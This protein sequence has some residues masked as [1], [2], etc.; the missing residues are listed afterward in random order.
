MNKKNKSNS[1]ITDFV[2]NPITGKLI[3][4]GSRIYNQLMKDNILKLD[5]S[6]RKKTVV[7]DGDGDNELKKKLKVGDNL[8]L[9]RRNGKIVENRRKI[10]TMENI[11]HITKKSAE[12][13]KEHINDFTDDMDDEQIYKKVKHLLSQKI[14]GDV[15]LPKK[16]FELLDPLDSGPIYNLSDSD[17]DSSLSP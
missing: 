9:V 5:P 1:D 15:E 17:S 16:R 14:I 8:N 3:K 12:I 6:T 4:I 11:Q 10:T 7:Y 13:V 2:V